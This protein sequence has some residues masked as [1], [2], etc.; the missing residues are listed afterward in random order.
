LLHYPII[1][2]EGSTIPRGFMPG[3]YQP[4]QDRPLTYNTVITVGNKL[5]LLCSGHNDSS[6]PFNARTAFDI[7]DGGWR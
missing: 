1:V 5:F 7:S 4:L 2:L 6:S 3:L